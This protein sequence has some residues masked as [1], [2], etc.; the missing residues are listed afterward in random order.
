MTI[1]SRPRLTVQVMR[2][3]TD[4]LSLVYGGLKPPKAAPH[5][6]LPAR[7]GSDCWLRFSVKRRQPDAEEEVQSFRDSL[8]PHERVV[9]LPALTKLEL[10]CCP[11]R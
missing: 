2:K 6:G 10:F 5:P 1:D 8:S 7:V 4:L 11:L 3:H 9:L